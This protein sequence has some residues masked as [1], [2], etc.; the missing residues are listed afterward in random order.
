MATADRPQVP[1][2]GEHVQTTVVAGS[3]HH[4]VHRRS[5]ELL[6]RYT[7]TRAHRQQ[8]AEQMGEASQYQLMLAKF[9]KHRVATASFY[10][11]VI[12]YAMAIF[13]PFVV[14]YDTLKRF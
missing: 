7:G 6:K 14:P 2:G 12:L 9:R 1:K 4:Y 11:L 8:I 13:A 5:Q 3:P 10:L